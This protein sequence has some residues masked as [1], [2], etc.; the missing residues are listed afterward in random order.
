MFTELIEFLKSLKTAQTIEYKRANETVAAPMCATSL[1]AGSDIRSN[2][3]LTLRAH[4]RALVHTGLFLKIPRN[5]FLDIRPR[6]GLALKHGITLL[7]TP[8]TVDA[9]YRGEIMVLM[10]NTSD[11]DFEIHAGDRIAQALLMRRYD[12]TWKPVDALDQT[13]RGTN[14]FGSSGI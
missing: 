9:D 8:A 6:S 7:N 5:F 2:E 4:Q 10:L 14:G 11:T 3:N 1:S 12:V 13:T